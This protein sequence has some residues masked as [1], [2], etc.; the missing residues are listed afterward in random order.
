[1]GTSEQRI[2]SLLPHISEGPH[3]ETCLRSESPPHRVVITEPFYLSI[4]EISQR[5][6]T[7]VMKHNPSHFQPGTSS[8]SLDELPDDTGTLP[9]EGVTWFDAANFCRTLSRREDLASPYEIIDGTPS[10]NDAA[11]GYR[12]P[13]EAEWE[14]ACLAGSSGPY[15]T[16]DDENALKG[17]A[18]L[19]GRFGRP[20]PTGSLGANAFGVFD[21]HGNVNEWVQDAWIASG[22][23]ESNTRLAID[24]RGPR[25]QGWRVTRGG[26]YF[27]GPVDARA[28]ARYSASP[29]EPPG[30]VVGFRIV[31]PVH[32]K[33]GV[34]ETIAANVRILTGATS[35]RLLQWAKELDEDFLP[36]TMNPRHGVRP[37]QFDAIAVPNETRLPWQL[38]LVDDPEADFQAMWP[39]HRPA[40]RMP[41]ERDSGESFQTIFLWIQDSPFWQTWQGSRD[42]IVE[43]AGELGL[44]GFSPGSLF[45]IVDE[46]GESWMLTKV[47]IPGAQ[48]R[49]LADVTEAELERQMVD[50]RARGW[51]PIRLMQHVGFDSPRFAVVFRDNPNRLKWEFDA[52]LNEEEYESRLQQHRAEGI[53]PTL[54]ASRQQG[55]EV[56]YRV[57]WSE[58]S[59]D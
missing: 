8:G 24:P 35:E 40:W 21:M 58:A 45:A 33:R 1:M 43:Q 30:H 17:I 3:A 34:P 5:Q 52:D 51:R 13:T 39:S 12:L 20:L 11:I 57:V 47:P 56:R 14:F 46:Q 38:H 42:F 7:E 32:I 44:E 27:Y 2:E 53:V 59:S 19:G 23:A 10:I 48:T 16:G 6:F 26:D 55:E 18:N 25:S 15:A 36:V 54:L 49:F 37:A 29:Q 31:A 28:A 9:V 22:Y 50:F 4:H 41:A